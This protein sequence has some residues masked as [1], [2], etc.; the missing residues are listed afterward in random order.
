VYG[1]GA[2][3]QEDHQILT[4]VGGANGGSPETKQTAIIR[5]NI[6]DALIPIEST[7]RFTIAARMPENAADSTYLGR[8]V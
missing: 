2:W 5:K 6:L 4:D 1:A 7:A 8:P 3:H